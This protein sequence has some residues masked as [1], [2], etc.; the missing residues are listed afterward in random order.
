MLEDRVSGG[1]KPLSVWMADAVNAPGLDKDSGLFWNLPR[2]RGH[3]RITSTGGCRQRPGGLYECFRLTGDIK[4]WDRLS[5]HQF[6]NT[7]V[8]DHERRV[9][10]H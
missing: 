2:V 4:Y 1:M 5:F 7:H 9:V 3:L 8:I 10:C 6:I